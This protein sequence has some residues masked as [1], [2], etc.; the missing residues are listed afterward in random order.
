MP[1]A[2]TFAIPVFGQRELLEKLLASIRAQT[3]PVG[4]VVVIDNGSP[5]G[6]DLTAERGGARVIRM[7][8]NTGFAR[9]VNRGIAE[10]RTEW[11]AIVNTDVELAPDWLEKLVAAIERADA[12]FATGKVLAASD[13]SV[14]DGTWDALCRG[15]C[16]LRIGSGKPDQAAF[17]ES[18][19]IHSPPL[20]CALLN[21]VSLRDAGMLDERFESYLEDVDLGL[22][23]ALAAISGI[24]VPGARAAHHG[25]ATLGR[26]NPRVVRNLARNQ[27]LLI[28]KHYPAGLI[29]RYLWPIFVAQTLWGFVAAKHGA[30][31]AFLQGKIDGIRLFGS[32]RKAANRAVQLDR[33]LTESERELRS[34]QQRTGFDLYWRL[35]F[36]F[37]A[38]GAN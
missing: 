38:G 10:C 24:Y 15:G 33:I 22:R 27:I 28:A 34:I 36:F 7:G 2:V 4:E 18:R 14:I 8:E 12:K 20:T 37:T 3:Y 29:V 19:A 16:A 1:F 31:G 25:S 30:L 11:I 9:A 35:Y 26:W 21:T 5:D 32:F 23:F 13:H 17:D 6:A